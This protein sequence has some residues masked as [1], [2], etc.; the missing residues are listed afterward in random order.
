MR[1]V[2]GASIQLC[3]IELR[4]GDP[5][6]AGR[7]LEELEGWGALT[8][9]RIVSARLRAM[10]AA[11][12]GDPGEATRSAHKVTEGAADD[13]PA[14][15][16]LEAV[17]AHGIAA[18]F[19]EDW[20]TAVERLTSVWDH[21]VAEGI[22]DP[23]AFPVAG[24]LV[25]ALLQGNDAAGARAVSERLFRLATEQN[26]PWGRV[27][28]QR[29]AAALRLSSEPDDAADA[30]LDAAAAYAELGLAFDHARTLLFAGRALRRAGKRT[31]AR[32]AL[33]EAEVAFAATGCTGW[34]MAAGQELARLSGRRPAGESELT[35]SEQRVVEL[36]ARGLANKE[37]AAQLFVS[38][39][40]V[41][42]HLSHAY[43]KLGV[44]SRAELARRSAG[45]LPVPALP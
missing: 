29:C 26:H 7:I 31:S 14:W 40:T 10:K 23:G 6:A 39:Y 30:L 22:D 24:D 21:T 34:A 32:R 17:R 18:L 27:T 5:A 1:L 13:C 25:E 9:M 4:S 11:V 33:G 19:E 37:I 2:L 8:E 44:R 41:E 15:D 12:Q 45:V 16:R 3:E 20:S 35:P 43:A 36:A 42:A 28:A 38:V